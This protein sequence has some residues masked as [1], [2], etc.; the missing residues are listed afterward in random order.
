[1]VEFGADPVHLYLA[2]M[3]DVPL[4]S[5]SEEF[6][7]GRQIKSSRRSFRRRMLAT[8]Y[9]LQSVAGL[10]NKV[11]EGQMRIDR[12]LEVAITNTQHKQQLLALLPVNLHT[13]RNLIRRN[14]ADYRIAVNRRQPRVA[15]HEAWQ[16][17]RRR[18]VRGVRLLEELGLR[19]EPLQVIL[20]R[21]KQFSHRMDDLQQRLAALRQQKADAESIR[22]L[23]RELQSLMKTTLESPATLR[24]HLERSV[25]LQ[26]EYESA[27]RWLSASNLRLVVSIAKRY[28]N[29]GLSFLDLIQE[30]NTGLMRAVDKFECTKGFKFAT[31]ATWWIRQ[32]ISRAIADQ[33]RTIRVPIHMLNTMDEVLDIAQQ[34]SQEHGR[35]PHLEETAEQAGL[36]VDKT[37]RALRMHRRPVSLDDT[38]G[39][40]DNN[41]LGEL[42]PDRHEKDL[43][44]DLDHEAL[45]SRIAKA[46]EMLNYREREIIRLRYGL[47]DGYVYTMEMIGRIFSVSRERIRQI[48]MDAL[49]KLQH[50]RCAEQLSGFLDHGSYLEVRDNSPPNATSSSREG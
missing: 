15:R 24:R 6:E 36:P 16:R 40:H 41:Y 45:K 35:E 32:A 33:S 46:L 3:S 17:L 1:M 21:M 4:M 48:E 29:R 38:V 5:R 11:L 27:R 12:T 20:G 42:L 31:Y 10:L 7:A 37:D 23:R 2:Q 50:P 25:E 19:R 18:R 43:H 34:F 28:R 9:A 8:D 47:A 49:R 26:K 30:G 14:R 44:R 22:E 39:S 13:L